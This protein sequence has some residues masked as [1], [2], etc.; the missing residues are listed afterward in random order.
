MISRLLDQTELLKQ[1]IGNELSIKFRDLL[2]RNILHLNTNPREFYA[3]QR[4]L[5]ISSDEYQY[6]KTYRQCIKYNLCLSRLW[7][8]AHVHIFTCKFNTTTEA[9]EF[10]LIHKDD[11]DA[12]KGWWIAQGR[13]TTVIEPLPAQLDIQ[14]TPERI[15]LSAYLWNQLDEYCY[16]IINS[17]KFRYLLTQGNTDNDTLYCD[18]MQHVVTLLSSMDWI[19]DDNDKFKL[20][21]VILYNHLIDMAKFLTAK[22]RGRSI[23]KAEAVGGYENIMISLDKWKDDA[24]FSD[25]VPFG[26]LEK[27]TVQ[28]TLHLEVHEQRRDNRLKSEL[29]GEESEILNKLLDT[30]VYN[31][32]KYRGDGSLNRW[33]VAACY[34]K[35][36]NYLDFC[37]K[38]KNIY[39][40]QASGN[41]LPVSNK[42]IIFLRK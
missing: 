9:A 28:D 13:P 2:Y 38:I 34:E 6:V 27:L 8:A 41:P 35:N 29:S 12:L 31:K 18:L 4:R 20:G 32:R 40:L 15:Q 1:K 33:L 7:R 25:I 3:E 11:L 30:E 14:V 24:I 16:R 5:G 10:Y 36:V 23:P 39:S 37:F 21:K 19:D 22:K 17:H 26:L 42:H